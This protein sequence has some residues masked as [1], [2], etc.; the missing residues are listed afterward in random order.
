MYQRMLKLDLPKGQSTFLWGARNTGKS[1][2]LKHYFPHACYYNLLKTNEFN[3]LLAQPS[4]LRD[5]LLAL[6]DTQR[7]CPIIID[8]VQKIPTLLDE[9][10]WLIEETD[11]SFILCGSSARKLK[12]GAANLLG[13]RAWITH[14]YPLIYKEISHFDLLNALNQ[15]L[16]PTHYQTDTPKRALNAYVNL[17]LKEEIQA[18]GFVRNLAGF[19]R[20]LDVIGFC[21]G[22][23]LNYT[24]IARDCGIDAKT[25]KEY[26]QILVDTLIGYYIYPYAQKAKRQLITSMPKFYL[27]DTGIANH[28]SRQQIQTLKG[29]PA[30]KAF[31]HFILMELI[32]YIGLKNLDTP[33]QYWRS[34]SG[35]EVDFILNHSKIAIEVKI[36]TSPKLSDLTGLSA[37][38]DDHEP[39]HA[40]VVCQAPRKRI[41]KT[42]NEKIMTILPWQDFLEELWED[43]YDI[44]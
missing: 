23:M 18:E 34:K 41:V 9:I 39:Q 24:S 13:G 22:E 20:F 7:A 27:F 10:H 1:T 43:R 35:L 3:R 15:G 16:L 38:C 28:L 12:R 6:N 32:A 40:L 31:E 19:T 5:E 29:I 14:F 44:F 30:G 21:H 42:H 17:Y 36:S 2:Y 8:E 11:L 25:V 33:I 37:F 26:Y 4:L